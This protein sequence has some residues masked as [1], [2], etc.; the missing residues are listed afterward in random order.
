MQYN[1]L[2]GFTNRVSQQR[3][4]E[5]V[6]A[7]VHASMQY[8]AAHLN[9]PIGIPRVVAHC[10]KSRA[11][12]CS[13]FKKEIGIGIGEYITLAKLREAKSLLRYTGK[14]LS[15]ISDYLGFSSQPYFQNVFKKYEGVTP[16]QYRDR[17]SPLQEAVSDGNKKLN[18]T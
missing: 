1:M 9:E 11:W 10:G 5:G 14:P 4:P 7:E 13:R 3:L 6:S 16:M 15:E 8:I 2:M 18:R 12:L 17:H